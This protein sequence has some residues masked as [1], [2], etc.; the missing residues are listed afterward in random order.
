MGAI[1]FTR[2]EMLGA[3]SEIVGHKSGLALSRDEIR[4]HAPERTDLCNGED[5]ERIRLRSEEMEDVV[6][7]LLYSVRN[8]PTP[9]VGHPAITLYHRHKAD[10]DDAARVCTARSYPI[11][12]ANRETL[13]RW[14][15]A[16]RSPA[17]GV[18][19]AE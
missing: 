10:A 11:G 14:I 16:M 1:W 4:D 8:I 9:S 6:R 13:R 5:D 7:E 15:D 3:V 18:Y 2:I 17:T 12:Q 19:M